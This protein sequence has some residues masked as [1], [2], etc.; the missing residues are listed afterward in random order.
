ME[1]LDATCSRVYLFTLLFFLQGLGNLLAQ[2]TIAF[3]PVITGLSAPMQ[4]VHAGDGSNRIFIV[5]KE[6]SII[7]YDANYV[8]KGTFLTLTGLLTGGEQGLLSMAFHPAYQTNG[9]FFVYYVNTDGNLEIKRF[10][11]SADP[12]LADPASGVIVLTIP[13]E[14]QTNHNGGALHFG[15]DGYL[16]L[17][18]GD[19]GGG[20]DPN[21]NAQN[22]SVL[23]GKMLRINVNTSLTFPFYTNPSSNSYPVGNVPKNEIFAVG[24]RN[25][26]RWSFDRQTHDMWIGDVG[27]GSE[28]E[29][30]HIPAP[31]ISGANFGWRCYEGNNE[32]LTNGCQ[33]LTQ[34]HFPLHTYETGSEAGRSVVGGVVYR[35]ILHPA[36]QGYYMGADYFSGD[37]HII[38]PVDDPD[39]T[40]TVQTSTYT[41]ISNFGEAENGEIYAV[42]LDAGTVYALL[43]ATPLPVE[44]VSFTAMPSVE[45]VRLSWQTA[46]EKN[47]RQFDIAYSKDAITFN[48]IGTVVT[49]NF[50]DGGTYH[51]THHRM[52]EKTQYY[53]LIMVDKD[54]SYRF[55][56]IISVHR[57]KENQDVNFVRPSFIDNRIMQVMLEEPF[58]SV[59]LIAVNGTVLL[60]HDLTNQTGKIEVPVGAM[61]SGMYIVRLQ[62]DSKVVN[63]KVLISQ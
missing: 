50:T 16:Y 58:Q 14:G 5:Q 55:S 11:V 37:I 42:S 49:Q 8:R 17:S 62:G 38:G 57:N 1:K 46:M 63:Q 30:N 59:E 54:D 22:T 2:P 51:F 31:A 10:K 20:N 35:G 40:I 53:R 56:K 33:S 6:G 7:V 27:Q 39:R 9:F 18:T 23:L 15:V 3:D 29:I 60:K 19:G 21:N 26:F 45:G 44:L 34:F 43:P 28:E 13:H 52:V 48:K 61:P 25:P 4:L 12:D 32:H 24:L 41:G 36:L 47:F